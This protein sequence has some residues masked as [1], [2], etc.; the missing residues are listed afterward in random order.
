MGNI[1]DPH[2][3]RKTKALEELRSHKVGVLLQ[4]IDELVG[5]DLSALEIES[6]LRTCG[7]DNDCAMRFGKR[8]RYEKEKGYFCTDNPIHN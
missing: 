6:V 1:E 2:Q 4:I 5:M 8:M 7:L 3:D